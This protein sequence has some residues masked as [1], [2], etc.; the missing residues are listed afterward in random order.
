M[1]P[2][3]DLIYEKDGELKIKSVSAETKEQVEEQVGETSSKIKGIVF[4]DDNLMT[5]EQD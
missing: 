2:K 4:S 1:T 5:S 3:Y